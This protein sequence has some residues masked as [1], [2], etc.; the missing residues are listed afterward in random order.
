MARNLL[1][2]TFCSFALAF[3][4]PVA[5]NDY[6]WLMPDSNGIDFRQSPPVPYTQHALN[7][8]GCIPPVQGYFWSGTAL[9][10][11]SRAEPFNLSD[12]NGNLLMY[13]QS[14]TIW[15]FPRSM[16]S[17]LTKNSFYPFS[18]YPGAPGGRI[19]AVPVPGSS[20]RYFLLAPSL[21]FTWAVV[22]P[23]TE[24]IPVPFHWESTAVSPMRVYSSSGVSTLVPKADPDKGWWFYSMTDYD[25]PLFFDTALVCFNISHSGIKYHSYPKFASNRI[26]V[27]IPEALPG[28]MCTAPAGDR[29]AMAEGGGLIRVADV[30]R[31]T[32]ALFNLRGGQTLSGTRRLADCAFSP[33]GTKLYVS[34]TSANQYPFPVTGKS[35]I[36]QYDLN[37]PDFMLHPLKLDSLE[38]RTD[39]GKYDPN[40]YLMQ[41]APDGKIYL[42]HGFSGFSPQWDSL[43]MDSLARSLSVIS[44]PNAAGTACGYQRYGYW[45]QHPN[46][47]G[48]VPHFP[49]FRAPT[50]WEP[51]ALPLTP[52]PD[53]EVLCPTDSV[54]IGAPARAGMQYRWSP[55]KYLVDST[56]AQP[57]IRAWTLPED[58]GSITFTLLAQDTLIE[59]PRR[60]F[61]T[62]TVTF[63]FPPRPQTG[64]AGQD[65]V[66]ECPGDM[67]TPGLPAMSGLAYD[68]QPNSWFTGA[69]TAQP[70]FISPAGTGLY[71]TLTY[72]LSATDTTTRCRRA[73][74]DSAQVIFNPPRAPHAMAGADVSTE[75]P[76]DSVQIGTKAI[77]GLSYQ[78]NILP[79]LF[80]TLSINKTTDAQPFAATSNTTSLQSVYVLELIVTNPANRCNQTDT[81][82]VVLRM[83]PPPAPVPNA[84]TSVLVCAGQLVTLGGPAKAG[85]VYQWSPASQPGAQLSDPQASAPSFWSSRDS[86]LFPLHFVLTTTDPAL[87]CNQVSH[88][89]VV[90]RRGQPQFAEA[91]P[92]AIYC[93]WAEIGVQLGAP[94]LPLT[95]YQWEP[96]WAV[97]SPQIAAPR[98]KVP[99]WKGDQLEFIL[100]AIQDT[101]C[102]ARDTVLVTV[103][104]CIRPY[105]PTALSS[106]G[107]DYNDFFYIYNLPP[108]SAFSVFDRWGIRI[109]HSDDY[110]NDWTP[111]ALPEGLYPVLLRTP[112]GS[113]YPGYV[114]IVR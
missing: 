73:R 65:F 111:T 38:S 30:D 6:I 59:C 107:D 89:P 76:G 53:I 54:Y 28:S 19:K 104:D 86:S 33:D 71:D 97:D 106:N 8:T 29:I 46:Y 77:A 102:I 32:G 103:D 35:Y 56:A 68:W 60:G 110:Q 4:Q 50:L 69:N 5:K 23:V 79:N 83:A 64:L 41:L 11:H 92:N 99:G 43:F 2:F 66:L 9:E 72:T 7:M 78:W 80:S 1:F 45:L 82:T 21:E 81:D 24:T 63:P 51:L 113:Q 20:S 47:N 75:C 100:T 95:T 88:T 98:A 52:A 101:Y 22:D 37:D 16:I 26:S 48:M 25:K 105:M 44:N 27:Q 34:E 93:Q 85:L 58:I 70:T 91:G 55:G 17:A 14:E 84:D 39:G 13:T 62:L 12:K 57:L 74:T 15:G 40:F 49:P 87:R 31:C 109:F 112:D 10:Y 94:T 114:V 90:V 96:A 61:D 42:G 18:T 36:Y 108:G 67:A 3:A